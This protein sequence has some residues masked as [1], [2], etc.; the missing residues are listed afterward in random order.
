MVSRI[1]P[2]ESLPLSDQHLCKSFWWADLSVTSWLCAWMLLATA[3]SKPW[4]TNLVWAAGTLV[5]QPTL[6][7]LAACSHVCSRPCYRK[8]ETVSFWKEGCKEGTRGKPSLLGKPVSGF[9]FACWRPYLLLYPRYL[10]SLLLV[11]FQKQSRIIVENTD[12]QRKKKKER[13]KPT[14]HYSTNPEGT[15]LN[16]LV[17]SPSIFLNICIHIHSHAYVYLYM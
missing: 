16:S 10:Q 17:F 6:S 8:P 12:K 5:A 1:C 9:A 15:T 3:Q 14:N 2:K 13:K 11:F 4:L 7:L